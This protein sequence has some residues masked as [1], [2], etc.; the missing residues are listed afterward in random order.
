METRMSRLDAKQFVGGNAAIRYAVRDLTTLDMAMQHVKHRGTAVQAGGCLGVFPRYL[1][2]KFE[3][4]YTFEPDPDLFAKMVLNTSRDNVV[5]IQAAVGCDRGLVSTLR[6][7]RDGNL[8]RVAHEGVTHVVPGGRVPI[9][10]ID[11]LGLDRCD[12]LCLDVEGYEFQALRGA[13]STI[14]QFHPVVMVELN[15]SGK[16]LGIEDDDVRTY[17][18][19]AGYEQVDGFHSDEIYAHRR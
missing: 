11:D 8:A 19:M 13:L 3:S 9:L 4:V 15:G 6:Q 2:T 7:R 18:R 5:K 12:L 16:T 17:L 10:R 1:S 14:S